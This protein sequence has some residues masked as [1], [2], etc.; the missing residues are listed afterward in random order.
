MK[1]ETR[2]RKALKNFDK[3]QFYDKNDKNDNYR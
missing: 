1:I 3:T 2:Y